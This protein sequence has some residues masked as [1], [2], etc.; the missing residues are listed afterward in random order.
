[1]GGRFG[2]VLSGLDGDHAETRDR[3]MELMEVENTSPPRSEFD[4]FWL[5][6]HHQRHALHGAPRITPDQLREFG[7]AL[8]GERWQTPLAHALN[9]GDRRIREYLSGA[10]T[11]QPGLAANI[12]A[13][14]ATRGMALLK[15]ADDGAANIDR[16]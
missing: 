13:L 5:G 10:R 15:L 12:A 3:I 2:V 4:R 9:I 14:A 6:Y 1:M 16:L 8:Y 11:I 7:E